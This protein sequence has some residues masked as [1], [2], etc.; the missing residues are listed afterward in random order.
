MNK[1]R[2]TINFP[3]EQVLQNRMKEIADEDGRDM[4]VVVIE[5]L[6]TFVLERSLAKVARE[7]AR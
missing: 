7:W 6:A 4:E 3:F 2:L 5:A 1:D